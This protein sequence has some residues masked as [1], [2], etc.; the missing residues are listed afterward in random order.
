MTGD[1]PK[2]ALT[3][4]LIGIAT[5]WFSSGHELDSGFSGML[6]TLVPLCVQYW[7][8]KKPDAVKVV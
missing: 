1:K 6:L 5:W 3:F 2:W 7:V 4:S 8:R